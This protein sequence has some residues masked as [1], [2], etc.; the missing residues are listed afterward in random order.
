MGKATDMGVPAPRRRWSGGDRFTRRRALGVAASGTAAAALLA[1]CGG[2]S[3]KSNSGAS[4]QPVSQQPKRGGTITARVTVDPFD[5]D[6]TYLG[7]TLPCVN[8]VRSAYSAMLSFKSGPGVKY[9]DLQLQPALAEKWETPDGQTYT[10]HLR[11][12][13]K[14]AGI[15]PVNGREVTSADVKFSYEYLSRTGSIKDKNLPAADQAWQFEGMTGI[16]TPDPSTVVVKFAKP[17]VPFLNYMGSD[18]NPIMPHEVFDQY[19]SFKDHIVG[20]G[21]WQLD[22]S[23]SQKGSRWVWKRNP[24]Y[25]DSGRPYIDQVTWL[26][27]QDDSAA[28]AAFQTKQLDLLTG[29]GYTATLQVAQQVTKMRPDAVI[30]SY[31]TPSPVPFYMMVSKPPLNDLRVRQAIG[32]A[33]DRDEFVTTFTQGKGGWAL[34]GAFPDTFS[35]E[36]MKQMLKHDPAQAKQLLA[37]AGYP[38]GLDLEFLYPG[39]A[40]GDQYVQEVELTQAQLKKVGINLNLQAADKQDWLARE[41][42][43]Q[44]QLSFPA[45]KSL[46][47]DVDSYLYA[48]FSPGS[49]TN[50]G[51]IND[52]ELTPL[53]D[54][55][56]RELDPAKRKEI[57]RQAVKRINVDQAWGFALFSPVSQEIW[58]PR[59]ANFAP[60]FGSKGFPLEQSWLV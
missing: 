9:E 55:Q 5:W 14:F 7:K 15:A 59:L 3:R 6:V 53:L 33:L 36:E 57:I 19:G 4:S 40:Y 42:K 16:E 21:A 56:R 43:H 23:A 28:L 49:G 38:N 54:A 27:I 31:L 34:A 18:D 52:P 47:E 29:G 44:F 60:N 32:L 25:W 46:G 58:A 35:Q 13:A 10:F 20:T 22:D 24:S 39:K 37:A 48:V 26:V 50:Y 2:G 45:G 51:D 30:N 41:R 12:G 17:F 11:K 8:G 1:S